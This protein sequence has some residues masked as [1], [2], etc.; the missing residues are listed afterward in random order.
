[1]EDDLERLSTLKNN[2]VHITKKVTSLRSQSVNINDNC[3]NI[4]QTKTHLSKENAK[5]TLRNY[6][7]Q[8]TNFQH[9]LQRDSMIFSINTNRRFA[10]S[11]SDINNHGRIESSL[12]PSMKG[13]VTATKMLTQISNRDARKRLLK[14]Y[15]LMLV[16]NVNGTFPIII[17]YT[18]HTS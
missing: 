12:S 11:S 4:I 3:I 1:M 14:K 7:K 16:H 13:Q 6:E 15:F 9:S 18:C 17:Y 8:V 5:S 2:I 10:Y